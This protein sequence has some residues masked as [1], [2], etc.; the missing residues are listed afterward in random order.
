M[1]FILCQRCKYKTPSGYVFCK[2]CGS[3]LPGAGSV[4]IWLALNFQGGSEPDGRHASA[5]VDR[6]FPFALIQKATFIGRME[7]NSINLSDV[8]V[9]RRH[10]VIRR[11]RFGHYQIEDLQ[12][13]NGT[14]LNG[15]RLG[16]PSIV[17]AGDILRLGKTE[18][19]FEE[20]P[21]PVFKRSG[22]PLRPEGTLI[23]PL[24]SSTIASNSPESMKNTLWAGQV[25]GENYRPKARKGWALKHLQ[26]EGGSDYFVLKG[27]D[28]SGY[29]RLAARDVFLWELMDGKHT[30][31][32]MLVAYLQTYRAMG[33]DRLSNLLD[34]LNKL[35]FLQNSEPR[36][37]DQ[38]RGAIAI[39]LAFLRRV[40]GSF[41]QKQFPVQGADEWITRLYTS[42]AWRFYTRAG[43]LALGVIALAGLIAFMTILFQGGH[44]LFVF[45]GSSVLGLILLA[46]AGTLSIF[47][48]EMGHALTVK[49][50]N[51]QVRKVGFMIY[52]GMPVFFVDTSDMWME[53]KHPR[54]LA[55]LAGPYASFL[56]ASVAS[57]AMLVIPSPL[58][59]D[60]LFRLAAWSFI[61]AFF[62]L[63]PLLELDGYFILIDWLEM[64]LL[65]KHSLDFVRHRLWRK[66][67]NRQAF[68]RDERLFAIFGILSALWSAIAIGAFLFYEGPWLLGI[69]HGDQSALIWMLS[70]I[71][72]LALLG[73]M[74]IRFRRSGQKSTKIKEKST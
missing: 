7:D 57:L 4:P 37:L 60:L 70:V 24:A 43:Q 67:W 38:P 16:T 2:H 47:L 42:F 31:R 1:A 53:P 73:L 22:L 71:L 74:A 33:A 6:L 68:S 49:S 25:L 51:R 66:L 32:D 41:F 62:N 36:Q 55:S 39:S 17:K 56:F 72:L 29:L 64:P 58:F 44:S 59:S 65:R 52:F 46:L 18:L 35:D 8:L 45:A 28:H 30:L 13:K 3:S 15:S 10:A 23:S 21:A 12:S 20:V 11:D 40:I 9:S 34:E 14:F 69:I 5:N 26:S 27:L 61:D 50:Y 48:H 19:R 54:I 63:N